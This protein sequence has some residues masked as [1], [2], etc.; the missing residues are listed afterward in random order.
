MKSKKKYI[1]VGVV[2]VFAAVCI[3]ILAI[4]FR[5]RGSV[6]VIPDQDISGE[7]AVFYRQDDERWA[8]DFLGESQSTMGSSGCLVTCIAIAM[9]MSDAGEDALTNI[10]ADDMPWREDPGELNRYLSQNNVYDSKGNLQWEELRKLD[11]F[12][13]DV[14]DTVSTELIQTCLLEGRY[15]IARVRMNGSGNF[16]YVL[17]V[18][19]TYGMFYCIDPLS[20][21]DTLVPLAEY[22]NRV[23]A[24]RCVYPEYK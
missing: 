5:Q 23:Y 18:E 24:L 10:S 9:E 17:I 15:P 3:G 11:Y 2:F 16:H 8:A 6:R 1:L 12:Q 13:V 22:N 20:Q 21:Y 19:S 4:L 7:E 14:Y